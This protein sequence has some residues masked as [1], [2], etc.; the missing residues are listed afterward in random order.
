MKII[1]VVAETAYEVV[2]NC[3][4]REEF[5]EICEV[6]ARVAVVISQGIVDLVGELPS[7]E[8]DVHVFT[9][10]DGEDGKN[11]E[12]LSNLWNWLGAAGFTRSD[13]VIGIGGRAT[14]DIEGF[15]AAPWLRGIG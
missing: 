11:V 6:R 15:A 3:Q 5:I 13:L 12:T 9:I 8:A 4:W 14:A 10:P 1:P 7:V 2:I